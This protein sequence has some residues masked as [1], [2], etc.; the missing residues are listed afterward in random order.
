MGNSSRPS[1]RD[2]LGTEAQI[3]QTYHPTY[4]PVPS[5]APPPR[6][7]RARPRVP[8][9]YA[10]EPRRRANAARGRRRCRAAA[11]STP[12]PA[13]PPV[14]RSLYRPSGA[15]GRANRC[16]DKPSNSTKWYRNLGTVSRPRHRRSYSSLVPRAPSCEPFGARTVVLFPVA[17]RPSP[18]ACG[19]ASRLKP[20]VDSRR[21]EVGTDAR[22]CLARAR[23]AREW[24]T[25]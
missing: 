3:A 21:P 11:A 9:R 25:S 12:P 7:P 22:G 4:H 10:P 15:P 19:L 20:C 13:P 24:A 6:A 14:P 18:R 23:A 16:V 1:L 2:R 5:P 17:R 8:R